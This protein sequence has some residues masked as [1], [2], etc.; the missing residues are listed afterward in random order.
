MQSA[1]SARCREFRTDRH[2]P[3]HGQSQ[4]LRARAPAGNAAGGAGGRRA[5]PA[6][7][8]WNGHLGQS[9]P[10][11]A[12]LVHLR[13]S[14]RTPGEPG[15]AAVE[16][17]GRRPLAATP[18]A[19]R[20][21]RSCEGGD[22]G[23][24]AR[25]GW[26]VGGVGGV[27]IEGAWKLM[28]PRWQLATEQPRAAK[29]RRRKPKL[30]PGQLMS[31]RRPREPRGGARVRNTGGYRGYRQRMICLA[32]TMDSSFPRGKGAGQGRPRGTA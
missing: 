26:G 5:G 7:G 27:S 11:S 1:S 24:E 22:G 9:R 8:S 14:P 32:E 15:G 25:V 16:G 10:I 17:L 2:L 31:G 18:R 6:R 28:V 29:A 30:L 3:T 19:G 13:P 23:G 12:N 20:R 21:S 4:G